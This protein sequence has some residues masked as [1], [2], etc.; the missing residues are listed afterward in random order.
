MDFS[1]KGIIK[2]QHQI[3]S[4]SK[5][6]VSKSRVFSFRLALLMFIALGI[7]VCITIF[8]AAKAM[9]DDAPELSQIN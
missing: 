5:R 9:I 4:W 6:L 2:R 7:F 3:K 1:K 8:A